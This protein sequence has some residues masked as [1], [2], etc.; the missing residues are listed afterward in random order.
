MGILIPI[1]IFFGGTVIIA[2]ALS[3]AAIDGNIADRRNPD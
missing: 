1:L 2:G 3:Q